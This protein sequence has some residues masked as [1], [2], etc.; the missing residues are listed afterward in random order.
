LEI[1]EYCAAE[2]CL[3][4]EQYYLDLLT[5]EYNILKVAGSSLGR[6]H[7]DEAKAKMREKAL[8][9]ERLEELKRLHASA[10][11]KEHLNR[12]NSSLE[13]QAKRLAALKVHNSS[14]EARDH[15][16]RHLK[17]LHS[18]PEIQAKRLEGLKRIHQNPEYQAKRL[19]H[20][21][22]RHDSLV[23]RL[24]V[25]RI[26]KRLHSSPE[27]KEHLNRL[28]LLQSKKVEVLD[29]Q[30]NETTIYSSLSEAAIAIGV[31]QGSI[32]NAF[33]RRGDSTV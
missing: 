10:E 8:T 33:K 16:K 22:A 21:D 15:L 11:H 30:N 13:E 20:A 4:R 6:K 24:R 18:N 3:E 31:A 32:S 2:K 14:Q 26:L 5:P 19:E 23:P 7:S 27:H 29:S 17:H 1:L 28:N 9:P 12:L 25:P